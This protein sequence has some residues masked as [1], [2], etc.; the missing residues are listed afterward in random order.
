[1]K[2][3]YKLLLISILAITSSIYQ[4]TAQEVIGVIQG[5]YVKLL[6]PS[7]GQIIDASFI[8]LAAQNPGTPKAIIQ[9]GNEIWISQQIGDRIDRYD[10]DGQFIDDIGG[11]VA[12]GGLDNIRGMAVIDDSEVWVTNAGTNNDAPGTAIIRID[13]NGNILGNIST[14]SDS[15]FDVIDNGSGEAY[16]SYSG[17][18]SKIERRDYNGT[19]LGDIVG[20]GVVSFIQQIYISS[21]GSI[22][23]GVFSNNTGSGN[24]SGVYNFDLSNGNILDYWAESGLRGVMELNNGNILY[25]NSS[26]VFILDPSTGNS[27]NISSGS[28]Q[29][30][31]MLDLVCAEPPTGNETQEFCDGA[32]IED[33][34]ATGSDIQ[35]YDEAT[36]G[37][38]LSDSDVL[39]DGESYYASQTVSGCESQDRLE[40][41][42]IIANPTITGD[43][44]QIITVVDSSDATVDDLVVSPTNVTWYA[45]E[46]DALSETNP[47]P[48]STVIE[49]GES[50]YAV[51]TEDGC[52][53]EPF[54]V[55]V[56]VDVLANLEGID[57]EELKCYPNPTSGNFNISYNKP[58]SEYSIISLSGQTIER[59]RVDSKDFQI[60]LS[61]LSEGSYFLKIVSNNSIK[62]IKVV[63]KN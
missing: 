48:G 57:S 52:T 33:L 44:N 12:N 13:F 20:T 9:V 46:N 6:D 54:Q 43:V 56:A 32:T 10:L 34:E 36:G 47:L 53:S 45:T 30:F 23:A 38:V 62:T 37:N 24:N 29:Y 1:M 25:S 3:L 50:Y 41:E 26:G 28:A 7:N 59:K 60:D 17:G 27:N 49:N 2:K 19:V 5:D 63:K 31:G 40:I 11:Q 15:P 39:V 4:S 22:L 14:G 51:Y 42:V 18:G 21:S 58:I 55:N 8:D 35:W 61:S 16:I